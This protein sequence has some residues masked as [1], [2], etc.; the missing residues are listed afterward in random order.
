MDERMNRVSVGGCSKIQ[1][2]EGGKEHHV[3]KLIALR[4]EAYDS[5][6]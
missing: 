3:G 4:G 1:H 6:L 2:V 5:K